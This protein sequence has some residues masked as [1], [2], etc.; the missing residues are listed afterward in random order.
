MITIFHEI[1]AKGPFYRMSF[2]TS[3]LNL[4][5]RIPPRGHL[6]IARNHNFMQKALNILKTSRNHVYSQIEVLVNLLAFPQTELVGVL[7]SS[8]RIGSCP[9]DFGSGAVAF[10]GFP[11]VASPSPRFLLRSRGFPWIPVCGFLSP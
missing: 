7:A 8:I 1:Y 9:L 3:I 4:T 5:V 10:R 2:W 11:S 6:H